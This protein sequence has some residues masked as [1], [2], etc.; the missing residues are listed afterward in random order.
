MYVC[1]S[2]FTAKKNKYLRAYLHIFSGWEIQMCVNLIWVIDVQT[3]A[4]GVC[5]EHHLQEDHDAVVI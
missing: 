4:A 3:Q 1:M 5:L 2:R